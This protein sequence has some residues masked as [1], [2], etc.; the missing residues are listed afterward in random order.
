MSLGS[1]ISS[2]NLFDFMESALI[3]RVGD[4]IVPNYNPIFK[5]GIYPFPVMEY[6]KDQKGHTGDKNF[7]RA[8]NLE[9]SYYIDRDLQTPQFAFVA[10]RD[11]ANPEEFGYKRTESQKSPVIQTTKTE[12]NIESTNISTPPSNSEI[13]TRE[14]ENILNSINSEIDKIPNEELRNIL[15]TALNEISYDTE[16]IPSS[17]IEAYFKSSMQ[18]K[19]TRINSDLQANPI[20][21]DSSTDISYIKYNDG[22][23]SI[24]TKPKM[25]E[26][27]DENTRKLNENRVY[28]QNNFGDMFNHPDITVT[29]LNTL[30]DNFKLIE[31]NS[32][33]QMDVIKNFIK[34]GKYSPELFNLLSN[35]NIKSALVDINKIRSKYNIC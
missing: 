16:S 31:V 8:M 32:D 33:G 20:S 7:I 27:I 15:T 25:T 5:E 24:Y 19:I 9:G 1:D 13:N 2:E 12:E 26:N 4:K 34:T 6:D 30:V 28:L 11:L 29:D 35:E 18:E 22:K 3:G 23:L 14:V 21:Y 17:G 10:S